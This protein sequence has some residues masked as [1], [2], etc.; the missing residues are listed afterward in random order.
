MVSN[1]SSQIEVRMVIRVSLFSNRFVVFSYSLVVAADQVSG[2]SRNG[3]LW[4]TD[5]PKLAEDA[6]LKGLYGLHDYF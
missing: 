1:L 2:A 5:F 4:F 6:S 3:W